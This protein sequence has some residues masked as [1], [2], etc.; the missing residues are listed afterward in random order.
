MTNAFLTPMQLYEGTTKNI[1]GIH[2]FYISSENVNAY[3]VKFG[4]DK[5]YS[6]GSTIDGTRSHHSFI[7]VSMN[8]IEMRRISFDDIFSNVTFGHIDID[9]S[10]LQPGRYIACLMISGT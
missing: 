2:F 8:S 9:T 4:F 10:M 7:P 6:F 1:K 3:C 5:Q